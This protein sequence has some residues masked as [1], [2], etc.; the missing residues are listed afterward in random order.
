M[1][2]WAGNVSGTPPVLPPVFD[3]ACE[4]V[5]IPRDFETWRLHEDHSGDGIEAVQA[6]LRAAAVHG[7]WRWPDRPVVFISDPQDYLAP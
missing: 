4:L 1:G 6:S 7:A 2:A 3:D 5:D